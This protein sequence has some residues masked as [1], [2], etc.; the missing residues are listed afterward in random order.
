MPASV[1]RLAFVVSI[2]VMAAFRYN[3][4]CKCFGQY[5]KEITSVLSYQLDTAV[6][7][8]MLHVQTMLS[9]SGNTKDCNSKNCDGRGESSLPILSASVF[10][11]SSVPRGRN[12]NFSSLH[13]S[14]VQSP[15]LKNQGY[16]SL[17]SCKRWLGWSVEDDISAV[18]PHLVSTSLSFLAQSTSER[19]S[20]P[21]VKIF[22]RILVI[23]AKITIILTK[24]SPQ[25]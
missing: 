16:S 7:G 18:E 25:F 3:F 13:N 20:I 24:R 8:K 17:A 1:H 12:A 14:E 19:F 22:L 4:S 11:E 2:L 15:S 5:A 21:Q 10:H 23:Q 9:P 6:F